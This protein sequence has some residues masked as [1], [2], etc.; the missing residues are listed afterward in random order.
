VRRRLAHV[1][2]QEQQLTTLQPTFKGLD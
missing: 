1:C 2:Q